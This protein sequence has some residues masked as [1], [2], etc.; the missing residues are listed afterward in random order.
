MYDISV[1]FSDVDNATL[2][3]QV[4]T[5]SDPDGVLAVMPIRVLMS[6]IRHGGA[7]PQWHPC[8]VN[9]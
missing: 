4:T 7:S 1:Y 6:N 2:T 9:L 3:Y 8:P 5:L